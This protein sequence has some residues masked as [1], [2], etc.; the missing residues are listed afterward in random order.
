MNGAADFESM[1]DRIRI[2]VVRR[3]LTTPDEEERKDGVGDRGMQCLSIRAAADADR[4]RN[5]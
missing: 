2:I 4:Y 1:L 5:R 3:M